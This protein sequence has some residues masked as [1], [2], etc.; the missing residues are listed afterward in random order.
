MLGDGKREGAS[1]EAMD[2]LVTTKQQVAK[3]EE[4]KARV[5]KSFATEEL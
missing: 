4:V 3:I 2:H 1:E 5:F